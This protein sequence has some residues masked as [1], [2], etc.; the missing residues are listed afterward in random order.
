MSEEEKFD[1]IV[2]GGGLAGSAAAYTMAK[3]GLDVMLVERGAFCGAKNTSGG[4]LYGHSLEKLI[5]NFAEEAPIER[6]IVKERV[7][8]MTPGSAFTGEYT[9]DKLGDQ[10]RASY[11]VLR[12]KFDKWLADKA[13]EAGAMIATSIRVDDVIVKDGKAV[14]INCEGEEI[15]SDVVI[16]ADGVNSLLAQKL[17]M[18]KEIEQGQVAV[19]VKEVIELGEDVINQRFGVSSGEG[20]SWMMAGDPTGGN[21]GGA[22]LYTNKDSVSLGIVTTTSDIG[23]IE[24]SV[25]D[26]LERVKDHMAIR[27][28]IEGGTTREY[29]AHLVTEAGY[30][31]VPELYRDGVL[32]AGDA[33]A[34]VIN[35]GYTVRGMDFAIESGRL[36]GEA[37]IKAKEA[38][39]FSADSLSYYKTLLDQSFVMKDLKQYQK[40]PDLLECHEIFNDIPKMA[41]EFADTLLKVDGRP[42]VPLPMIALTVL[43]KNGGLRGLMDLGQKALEVL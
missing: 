42:P 13:E 32:V 16:L 21:L 19:G 26:M 43:A 28:L 7:S 24:L 5:P 34:F 40:F 20:V 17:G 38:S 18:K 27:P 22:F 11:S 25:P 41:D 15:M 9:S 35:L 14:G 37:V 3:A 23:R 8:M 39:D 30:N 6:K 10:G 2:V 31:M 36:A 29:S 4:R 12:S 1:A 33:A